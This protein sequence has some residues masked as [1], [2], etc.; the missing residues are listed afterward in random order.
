MKTQFN[1]WPVSIV[2]AF[3]CLIGGITTVIVI[4]ATHRDSMVSENYY[5]Q[6]LTYQNQIDGTV[7]AQKSGAAIAS[8]SASGNVVITMPPAQLAQNF[9]GTIELYRPSDS[10]LDRTLKLSPR[11]D[12]TQTLD[13]SKLAAGLWLVR[14][15]WSAAG[16]D[17]YLEQ[18]ITVAGI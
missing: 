8:D 10:K 4:A 18:K 1:P 9:S 7:R 17:Y 14:V 2:A 15:K 12:G 11:A 13:N 5:E 6:E 16:E 3:V